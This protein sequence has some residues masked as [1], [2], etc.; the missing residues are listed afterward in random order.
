VIG[1]DKTSS[2]TI[3]PEDQV[4]EAWRFP[5]R[6]SG[7]GVRGHRYHVFNQP[8]SVFPRSAKRK[9]MELM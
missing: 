3:I 2:N 8:R 6:F 1:D 5:A 4:P 7:A 9:D